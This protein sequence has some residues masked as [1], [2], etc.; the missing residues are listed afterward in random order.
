MSGLIG[1]P[2]RIQTD[3]LLAVELVDP[4]TLALV[5]SK[6]TL[7]ATGLAGNPR[8]GFSGRFVWLSEGDAWPSSFAFD[9]RG[10][11]YDAQTITAL[12]KPANLATASGAERLLRVTLRPT[13][14]YPFGDGLSVVRASL[15]ESDAAGAAPVAGAEIRLLWKKGSNWIDDGAFAVSNAAGDFAAW[16]RLPANAKPVVDEQGRLQLQMRVVRTINGAAVEKSM[17]LAIIDGRVNDLPTA[18]AWSA[19][20]ST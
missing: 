13:A 4:V 3:A 9:P 20:T 14:A 7:T 17:N 19:M 16:L 5:S 11:P 18:P 10:L 15:R 1:T 8:I 2:D 12:P 6:V